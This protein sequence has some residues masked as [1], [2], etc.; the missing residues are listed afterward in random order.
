MVP[1]DELRDQVTAV[2]VV[3]VTVAVNC[4][5]PPSVRV[6]VE[7]AIVTPIAGTS[8]TLIVLLAVPSLAVAET[9][10]VDF[11]VIFAG[12]VNVL[13]CGTP[14]LDG[15][16]VGDARLEENESGLVAQITWPVAAVPVTRALSV[17]LCPG[18]RLP[19]PVEP[20]VTVV[21]PQTGAA[22]RNTRTRDR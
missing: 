14:A 20:N 21:A 8:V 16:V 5:L 3:P 22:S 13:F 9:V 4:W 18:P 10:T 6:T 1:D 2:L 15:V 7:G 11:A 12:A 17:Q 19:Q